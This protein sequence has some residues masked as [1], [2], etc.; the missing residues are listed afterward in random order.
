[1]CRLERGG[2]RVGV[3]GKGGDLLGACRLL[4]AADEMVDARAHL[5]ELAQLVGLRAVGG[6]LLEEER[7]ERIVLRA[8]HLRELRVGV[9]PRH[10]LEGNAILEQVL[11]VGAERIEAV[12]QLVRAVRLE[13]A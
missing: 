2:A 3:R 9:L 6:A 7:L 1:M 10:R 8:G 13:L 12:L 4:H 11:E 5:V